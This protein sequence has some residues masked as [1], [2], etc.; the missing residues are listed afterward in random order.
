M[1][2]V[3][4]FAIGGG[5]LLLALIVLGELFRAVE[6]CTLFVIAAPTPFA[7]PAATPP[8]RVRGFSRLSARVVSV[9]TSVLAVPRL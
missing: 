2:G 5:V 9:L 8:R 3:Y 4:D 1:L 6:A 7:A